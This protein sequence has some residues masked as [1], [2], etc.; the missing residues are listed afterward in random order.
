[1][2]QPFLAENFLLSTAAAR[3]LYHD[4]A[5]RMPIFD[6][7]C[8]LSPHDIASDRIFDNLAQIWLGGD[9]YKWRAMRAAGV[10]ERYCTG[11]ASDEEKFMRWAETVPQTVRNP[12]HH[13]THLELRRY[14]GIT[15]VLDSRTAHDIYS[16]C[17]E[18]LRTSAF[19][20]RNLLRKMNVSA[21]CTTDDPVD[22]LRSHR[23]L[24]D[25]G[26]EIRVLPTF[27]PDK[28]LAL[29]DPSSYN[30]YLDKLGAA[31]GMEIT[32]FGS[33]VGALRNR[34]DFF[35]QQGCC[36]SDHGLAHAYAE[37]F[38]S[39][40]ID[41]AF[42]RIRGGK[43]LDFD[44]GNKLRSALLLELG[45]MVHEKGWVMILHL[46]PLRNN[47]TR[48][49]RSFGP[50][51][52]CDSLD[53]APQARSLSR[54]LDSLDATGQLPKTVLY[55]LNPADDAAIASMA[56]NFNDGTVRGKMQ[57]SVG[58]W[59]N[60]HLDGITHQLNVLS[61]I[62]LL[63][64]YIGLVTDSRSL[65]S[66]PRH[67]YFRRILCGML[68]REMEAGEIPDDRELVGKMV[69][70][71]CYGNAQAFFGASARKG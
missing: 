27:R 69:E 47:N 36:A 46:G 7:H 61:S 45:R 24:A 25:D 64:R 38:T 51:A 53:D 2:P 17:N 20:A 50:D 1:M 15:A 65:L 10:D 48:L 22:D 37:E 40:E 60:D 33:L 5:A 70:D 26:C 16:A 68:G 62:G 8:H 28:V 42:A 52:G 6:Y 29:D 34:R 39:Q 11:S 66:F 55:N 14:F 41:A 63:S 31:A 43:S 71:I 18:R 59:F 32:S 23:T 21:V 19:S 49:F 44:A 3:S 12:L 30:A 54:F 57:Y 58:W 13:W 4:H 9:H 56:G 35:Q 67:E